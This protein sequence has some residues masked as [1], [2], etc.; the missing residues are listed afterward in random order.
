MIKIVLSFIFTCS[1]YFYDRSSLIPLRGGSEVRWFHFFCF[2]RETLPRLLQSAEVRN[3]SGKVQ[4]SPICRDFMAHPRPENR[5]EARI[6]ERSNFAWIMSRWKVMTIACAREDYL[7][8]RRAHFA[9]RRSRSGCNKLRTQLGA[10]RSWH[11]QRQEYK[12]KREREH[13]RLDT[14]VQVLFRRGSTGRINIKR[15]TI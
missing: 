7:A 10:S 15:G 9:E 4:L 12:K 1:L 11:Y 3:E 5:N 13:K 6:F 14:N 2:Y 8:R